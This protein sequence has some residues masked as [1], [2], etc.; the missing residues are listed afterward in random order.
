M[1]GY[2]V[3]RSDYG[4]YTT[5]LS[6][7]SAPTRVFDNAG[8]TPGTQYRYRVRAVDGAGNLWFG[9][10]DGGGVSKGVSKFD[11]SNWVA[12]G[13]SSNTLNI[14]DIYDAVGNQYQFDPVAADKDGNLFTVFAD[15]HNLS[16]PLT[17]KMF[18][19]STGSWI[20]SDYA[21]SSAI[22]KQ[23]I[24]VDNNGN[25]FVAY[26]LT[27]QGG[28][29]VYAQKFNG[30]SNTWEKMGDSFEEYAYNPSIAVDK[31]GIVYV[32]YGDGDIELISACSD[33]FI[34]VWDIPSKGPCTKMEWP[35]FQHDERHTGTYPLSSTPVVEKESS[36]PEGFE[37][38]QNFPNPFN[39]ETRISFTLPFPLRVRVTVYSVSGQRVRTLVDGFRSQGHHKVLW[40]G[41][42]SSGTIVCGGVYIVRL[43]AGRYSAERKIV[44][45]R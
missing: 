25:A 4:S 34:Y 26:L 33:S 42:D 10:W 9:T 16:T 22:T 20:T 27:N 24:T 38:E 12:I 6:F 44:F 21:T 37:L 31:K 1:S 29:P 32:A 45:L 40:D 14:N 8:L 3:F 41:R 7:V 2:Q 18:N 39:S 19:S 28:G 11:G 5:V 23:S 36:L 35:V 17:L 15:S 30:S 43:K 13:D